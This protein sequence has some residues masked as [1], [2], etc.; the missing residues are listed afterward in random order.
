VPNLNES[1]FQ[2][3]M[4]DPGPTQDPNVYAHFSRGE[5]L[6]PRIT[7][8]PLHMGTQ[9]AAAD[10]SRPRSTG[11]M[12]ALRI[13]GEMANAPEVPVS[14]SFAN[15]MISD[16]EGLGYAGEAFQEHVGEE[17]P[18]SPQG[19]DD[20][21]QR[22][23]EWQQRNT[24]NLGERGL[25]YTNDAE[26]RG[27]ISAVVPGLSHVE[28]VGQQPFNVRGYP[29]LERKPRGVPQKEPPINDPVQRVKYPANEPHQQALFNEHDPWG[30]TWKEHPPFGGAPGTGRYA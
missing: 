9:Q 11:Q 28:V 15:T 26:D 17:P 25:Y 23:V 13:R 10:I 5:G 18:D 24:E 22:R 27:S 21:K 14:D 8:H 16:D 6:D 1:Q 4:F 7:D 3:R 12:Y 2:P 29:H 20:W 19:R 30:I